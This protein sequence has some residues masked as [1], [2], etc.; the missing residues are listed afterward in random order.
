MYQDRQGDLWL[1]T[2]RDGVFRYDG[3]TFS[4]F[5]VFGGL[6][7]PYVRSILE[8]LEGNL[9]FSTNRGVSRFDGRTFATFTKEDGLGANSVW[10]SSRAPL[11][12]AF[13]RREPV[14]RDPLH[15]IYH[16]RR[17]RRQRCAFDRGGPGRK[18]LVGLFRRRT[19]PV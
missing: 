6:P 14:G 2:Q 1:G 10:S 7:G 19:E 16:R 5:G 12:R 4:A 8:D 15:D 11:V 9:W 18:P 17:T 3:Q 13:L